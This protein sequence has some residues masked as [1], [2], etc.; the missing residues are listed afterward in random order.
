MCCALRPAKAGVPIVMV[1]MALASAAEARQCKRMVAL[2]DPCQIVPPISSS[3]GEGCAV[4]FI[5]TTT[6]TVAYEVTIGRLS[7]EETIAALHD[8]PV[9]V[10]GPSVV[11]LP[12]GNPKVGTFTYP[13]E[14]ESD[15]LEGRWYIDIH[16]H[17]F[18]GSEIRG[19]IVDM[20]AQLDG[21]QL[22]PPNASNARAWAMFMIDPADNRLDYHLNLCPGVPLGSPA[23]TVTINGMARHTVNG[24]PIHSL[25]AGGFPKSGAW[26]YDEAQ[27]DALLDGLTYINLPTTAAPGGLLRGQISASLVPVHGA[28]VVPP[29]TS[30]AY[31]Y[32]VL[33]LD[34]AADAIGYD[35]DHGVT[36][37]TGASIH[38]YAGRGATAASLQALASPAGRKLGSWSFG[39]A[40]EASVLAGLSYVSIR[41][42]PPFQN[43]AVRGQFEPFTL[44]PCPG[45]A[46]RDEA[47]GLPDVAVLINQW[48]TAGPEGDL[49]GDG[50]VGLA[51][52]ALVIQNW[53]A[54]CR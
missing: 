4:F 31:G 24:A 5:D 13:E 53:S 36:G 28:N 34:R 46:N 14:E 16:T 1:M 33:S 43:G 30:T 17:A 44:C 26:F 27:E 45:D 50:V 25:P 42:A 49:D 40:N 20:V 12:L 2:L 38:G 48:T 51:D 3:Q 22:V 6:N 7:D 52:M 47:V 29:T 39:A 11:G 32:G 18:P 21:Q 9:G 10:S 15:L 19:Q 54:R 37:E 41:A 23:G 35:L 8:A